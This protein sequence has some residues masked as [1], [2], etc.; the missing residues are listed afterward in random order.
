[1]A[2]SGQR[3]WCA[4]TRLTFSKSFGQMLAHEGYHPIG[5]QSGEKAIAHAAAEQPSAILLDLAMP[6]MNG[7]ETLMALKQDAR[8]GKFR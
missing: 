7:W 8:L 5:V 4:T 1:M 3:A 2:V 6:G